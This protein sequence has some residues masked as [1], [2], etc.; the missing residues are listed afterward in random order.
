MLE[1]SE[2]LNHTDFNE[3][4]P[5]DIAKTE[6]TKTLLRDHGGKSSSEIDDEIYESLESKDAVM[7]LFSKI[8][9]T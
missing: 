9:K 7:R 6:E 2:D 1:I 8:K 3:L 5:L 4:T